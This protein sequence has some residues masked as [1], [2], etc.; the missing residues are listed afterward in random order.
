MANAY[1]GY[2]NT[3]IL[4]TAH[5]SN[6][7]RSTL[8]PDLPQVMGVKNIR[9]VGATTAGHACIIQDA[10]GV[11]LWESLASGANYVESDLTE[12]V[13]RKDIKLPTLGSGRLYIT[14]GSVRDNTNR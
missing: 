7:L 9:W 4:D 11:V 8:A 6:L 13:W 12:R 3:F 10:D 1:N 5:A 2:S 14:V